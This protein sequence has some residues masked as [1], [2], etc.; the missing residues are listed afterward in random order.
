MAT[1]LIGY[2]IHPSK[3][4]TYENLFNAI[5]ALGA[6]WHHLDSTW[7]VVSDLSAVEIRDQLKEHLPAA[8]DQLLVIT[9]TGAARAWYGFNNSG[10]EWLKDNF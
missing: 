2:D 1:H 8:D 9:V 4:E 7:L 3:G 10:S 5:K 6:W